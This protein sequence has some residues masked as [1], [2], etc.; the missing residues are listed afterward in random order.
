M[1]SNEKSINENI[2][3]EAVWCYNMCKPH[4]FKENPHNAT[5]YQSCLHELF[6]LMN[7]EELKQYHMLISD[8]DKTNQ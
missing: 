7:E 5:R 2:I 4:K 1:K 3:K 6:A 8:N